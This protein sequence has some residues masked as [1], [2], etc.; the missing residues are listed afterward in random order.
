MKSSSSI[1]LLAAAV[2]LVIAAA[3]A[4]S[5]TLSQRMA[6][7]AANLVKYADRTNQECDTSISVAL[8]WTGAPPEKDLVAY[9]VSGYCDGA[10]EGVRRVCGEQVGK[11]AVKQQINSITCGFGTSRE[12]TLKEGALH[13]EINFNSTND[14]DFVYEYL[15]NAL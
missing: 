3:H 6:S 2:A 7:E 8:D 14:A 9:S 15:E 1:G 4:Q 12:I 5:S 10:L 13:Y 11:D